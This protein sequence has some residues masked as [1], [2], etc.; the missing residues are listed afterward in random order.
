MSKVLNKED[1]LK[2]KTVERK[3]PHAVGGRSFKFHAEIKSSDDDTRFIE[4]HAST[5]GLDLQGD[6]VLPEAFAD[7]LSDF[8]QVPTVTRGHNWDDPIGRVIHANI[9]SNGLFV[10]AQIAKSTQSAN[11][12][13]G[14]IKEGVLKAFS[15]GFDIIDGEFKQVNGESVYVIKKLRLYEIA[16]VAIPANREAQFSVVKGLLQG[17]DLVCKGGACQTK[18]EDDP[19]VEELT[20]ELDRVNHK[21][22]VLLRECSSQEDRINDLEKKPGF[23][24]LVIQAKMLSDEKDKLKAELATA[25]AALAQKEDMA[26]TG[27]F[28]LKRLLREVRNTFKIKS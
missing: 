6:V 5:S 22:Q 21:H 23:G 1:A 3:Q 18:C 15:I 4:G 10:K 24:R 25:K 19:K 11:E 20:A 16:V 26:E 17:D 12:T 7:G 28:L 9:D 13:W 27:E 14:L 8:M 2:A